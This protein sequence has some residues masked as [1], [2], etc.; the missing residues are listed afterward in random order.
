MGTPGY[1]SRTVAP[2]ARQKPRDFRLFMAGQVSTTFGSALTAVVLPVI[3]VEKF[4]AD[5]W[6]IGLLYASSAVPVVLFGFLVGVWSDRRER[7]RL[8][9]IA[10]DMVSIAAIGLLCLGI[11]TGIAGFY[12]ILPVSFLFGILTLVVEAL[13]FSHLETVIGDRTVLQ[14]RSRLIASER[15]GVVGRSWPVGSAHL[16]RRICVSA[17]DRPVDLPG[18]CDMPRVDQE[19]GQRAGRAT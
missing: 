13:Y 12:W 4:M 16:V 3:A 7:K 18:Q 9:L 15:A 19:S 5:E 11:S 17:G 14:A 10:A 8:C 2:T 1:E 6:Q